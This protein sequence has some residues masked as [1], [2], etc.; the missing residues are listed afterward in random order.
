[1][2]GVVHVVAVDGF[3]RQIVGFSTMPRK[4]PITTYNTI[5]GPLLQLHGIWDQVRVYCGI[6]FALVANIQQYLASYRLRQERIPILRTTSRQNHRAE[7][8]WPEVN[9]R[10]NYPVKA[11][12]VCMEDEQVV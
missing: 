6:E 10:I 3:S 5:F 4:N 1:M 2:Y 8:I 11:V 12:L 7:K 9:A